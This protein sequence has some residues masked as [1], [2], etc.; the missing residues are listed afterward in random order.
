MTT[1]NHRHSPP[2]TINQSPSTNQ[3]INQS[4]NQTTNQST[5]QPTNFM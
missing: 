1:I 5:H 4:T 2:I 3:P